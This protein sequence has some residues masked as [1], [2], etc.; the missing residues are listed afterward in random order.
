VD[1]HAEV[2]YDQT[3]KTMVTIAARRFFEV[4]PGKRWSLQE[5][6]VL[7]RQ[8]KAGIPLSEL[9]VSQR[10]SAGIAYQLRQLEIYPTSH[11]TDAEVQLL[12][13]QAKAGAPPWNI[14]IHGRS[15]NAV[16]SKMLRLQLWKPKSHTQKPWT[17]PE[18]NLLKHLVIDCGYTARQA[19]ANGYFTSRSVD[20]IGQQMRRCAWKRRSTEPQARTGVN[21]L[22]AAIAR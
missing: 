14:T 5:K 22:S 18:L 3:R 6:Q 9:R 20:S 2:G 15:S 13:K 10:T 8:I 17:L 21:S 16:R 1:R 19:D 7:R 11:W 12:R 4:M